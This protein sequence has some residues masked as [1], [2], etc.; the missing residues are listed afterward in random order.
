MRLYMKRATSQSGLHMFPVI[1]KTALSIVEKNTLL[2]F[3]FH[4]G[5][6]WDKQLNKLQLVRD[7]LGLSTYYFSS[8]QT[9]IGRTL[10]RVG[11]NGLWSEGER[12]YTLQMNAPT[13]VLIDTNLVDNLKLQ[14]VDYTEQKAQHVGW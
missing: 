3:F 9:G 5:N 11:M 4:L 13:S 1:I 6:V 14:R 7:A 12:K 2:S 10:R 8:W